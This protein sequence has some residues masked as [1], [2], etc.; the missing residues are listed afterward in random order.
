[1][2]TDEAQNLCGLLANPVEIINRYDICI[3]KM[4]TIIAEIESKYSI[5]DKHKD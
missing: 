2:H 5:T 1:L 4:K 3:N